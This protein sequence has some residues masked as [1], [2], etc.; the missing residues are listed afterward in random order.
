MRRLVRTAPR[1]GSPASFFQPN[2]HGFSGISRLM[3]PRSTVKKQRSLPLTRLQTKN[4]HTFNGT[5]STTVT[6]ATF[7][8]VAYNM[9]KVNHKAKTK[10]RSAKIHPTHG[11][12]PSTC[13]TTQTHTHT[14]KQKTT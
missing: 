13:K 14:K 6:F 9:R 1:K 11:G 5:N 10:P 2:S 4:S 12:A 7:P 3:R 8:V